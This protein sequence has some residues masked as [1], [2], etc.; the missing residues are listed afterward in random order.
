[1]NEQDSKANHLRQRTIQVEITK[2]EEVIVNGY[3]QEIETD[4]L[5]SQ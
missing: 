5:V 2:H 1:M 3:N 4:Y